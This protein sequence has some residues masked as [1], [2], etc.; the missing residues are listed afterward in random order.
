[1]T[2][3]NLKVQGKKKKVE[4]KKNNIKGGYRGRK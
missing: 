4:R 2:T 3:I 1:M